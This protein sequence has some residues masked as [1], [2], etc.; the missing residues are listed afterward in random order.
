MAQG[1]ENTPSIFA[2]AHADGT[3]PRCLF[4]GMEQQAA[5]DVRQLG[6]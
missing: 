1:D 6:R 3:S 2:R 5:E 4:A